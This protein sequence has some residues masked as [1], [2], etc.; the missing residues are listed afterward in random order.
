MKK[1][2]FY[3]SIIWFC[4]IKGALAQAT[5][6]ASEVRLEQQT[7]L[8]KLGKRPDFFRPFRCESQRSVVLERVELTPDRKILRLYC[9]VG[10]AQI[11]IRHER[12]DEWTKAVRKKLGEGYKECDVRFFA[13]DIPVERFIPNY[14][15]PRD[16]R[17]P[18]RTSTPINRSPLV[19]R[20]DRSL[21]GRGL[22][23]RHIALWG[24]HGR[25]YH[26]EEDS[27]WVW[28]RPA[29]FGTIEDLH[30]QEFT[31]RYLAPMLENAGA[32]VVMARERDPQRQE[33]IVDND[34]STGRGAIATVGEWEK[35]NFGFAVRDTIREQ[36]PFRQGTVLQSKITTNLKP[37]ITYTF[38]LN[39]PD[40]YG[41]YVS[42][43]ARPGNLTNARYTV[44]HAGGEAEFE[45]NQRIGGG[46][47]VWLGRFVLDSA[48]KV[49][50]TAPPTAKEG[51]WLSADAVRIGGGMGNVERAGEVSGVSR[52][53]EAAR[54]WMQY[55]GV[56]DSIYAQETLSAENEEH[57]QL[58]YIDN[59]KGNGDWCNY[60]RKQKNI[61]LDVAVGL[62]TD[63]GT[64]DSIVGTMTIH[65]TNR[66]RAHY[67][68]GKCKLAGRD[69]ADLVQTQV[70]EDLRAKYDPTWTRRSMY[71]KSYAEISRPDVPA[72]LVEMFSHQNA[73]D[74]ALALDPSFRFDM[75]RAVYKGI[76]RFLADRYGRN[77]T[78]Q[79]LPPSRLRAELVGDSVRLNWQ[80]TP[81][82]LEKSAWPSRYRVYERL[83]VNGAFDAGCEVR[84]TELWVPLSRDGQLHSFRITAINEGGE[85]FPS[86]VICAGLATEEQGR[87][88]VVNGFTR[89]S[90]PALKKDKRGKILGFDMAADPG[91]PD[92]VDRSIVGPQ[93]NFDPL[94][95]FESNDR[96]G[97]GASS[98]EWAGQGTAGN[99]FD[100]AAVHGQ[101]WLRAGIS[102]S[103]V[104]RTAFE[105]MPLRPSQ[106]RMVDLIFG[107]QRSYPSR[108]KI[109][110]PLITNQLKRLIEAKIP[111]VV[112]G[113]YIGRDPSVGESVQKLLGYTYDGPVADSGRRYY[114][115]TFDRLRPL[116]GGRVI[117]LGD[118]PDGTVW[119]RRIFAFGFPIEILKIN[120]LQ[121]LFKL[122]LTLSDTVAK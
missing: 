6:S 117:P 11:S 113:S 52:Y 30:T 47:W 64:C 97:W 57:K 115:P 84:A 28:Q 49:V 51:A 73:N 98:T 19:R 77:Y 26:E 17:D 83:G 42:W 104:S 4:G 81:D 20:I 39:K 101:A 53:E 7:I 46:M 95:P 48:S 119:E 12:I 114:T 76:L 44:Y 109:F 72:I 60:I 92:G 107:A 82:P 100:Y 9:N 94:A 70:V 74:M 38:G 10:L 122:M 86:E 50:L 29:L 36:N 93:Q 40:E 89:V 45:V 120:T 102:V 58:D 21:Y 33:V 23:G 106:Y 32:V 108:Y 118:L 2:I 8:N 99:T 16:E 112:S 24:G 79:P 90:P 55:S 41:V 35:R 111:V 85:S 110:N 78:V 18:K 91:V 65:Y 87:V 66:C 56:P 116:D 25:Y 68:N 105:R 88:L 37:S 27:A 15:R 69:L 59:F 61:P 14:F 31:S 62:H 67:T 96:P 75:A 43:Q 63:A 54:Y 5:L 80:A 22:G 3:L 121:N 1:I 34:G 13:Y 71:D 103:S